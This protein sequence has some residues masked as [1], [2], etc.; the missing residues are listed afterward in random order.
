MKNTNSKVHRWSIVQKTLVIASAVIF[1]LSASTRTGS[2]DTSSVEKKKPASSD[3]VMTLQG[4]QEGTVFKDLVV[5][6]EDRI[7]I[8]FERPELHVDIDP[9]TAPGLEWGSIQEVL[10]RSELELVPPF[11]HASACEHSPYL[12]RPWL[13]QFASE[14]IARFRPQ[15]EG[16]DRWQLLIANSRGET[17]ASFE[18]NGKPP[19]QI[20][21]DGSALDGTAVPPG[22]TYSYVLEAFDRAGN[23]RSFVGQGFELPAYRLETSDGTVMLFSGR[24]ILDSSVSSLKNSSLPPSLLLEVVSRINQCKHVDQPVR[25]AVTARSFEKAKTLADGIVKTIEPLI[26]GGLARVQP[27]TKVQPDAPG[28]GTIEILVPK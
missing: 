21:W 19:R 8:E 24:E 5:E 25:V 27:V 12:A 2:A 18:G 14:S 4:D 10:D 11:L 7:R 13:D 22:L 16:V 28:D 20:C 15:V 23:K 3:S 1:S 9:Q 6:G 17:V 26:F